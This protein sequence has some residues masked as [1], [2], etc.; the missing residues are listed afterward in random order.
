MK[1]FFTRARIRWAGRILTVALV[2]YCSYN[3]EDIKE[4]FPDLITLQL[5]SYQWLQQIEARRRGGPPP[6]PDKVI[7]VEIDNHTFFDCLKQVGLEDVTD[8][9][10]LAQLINRAVAA[11]AAVVAL[12][13][14]LVSDNL[15]LDDAGR[16]SQN[17]ALFDAIANAAANNV[18]VVLTL[19]FDNKT[20]KRL[21]N[22]ADPA[23]DADAPASAAG[24]HHWDAACKPNQPLPAAEVSGAAAPR[25]SPVQIAGCAETWPPSPDPA[26]VARSGFDAAPLDRRRIPLLLEPLDYVSAPTGSSSEAVLC[27]SF[28]LQIAHA[29]EQKTNAAEPR[30]E[31]RL[32]PEMEEHEFVY[33]SFFPEYSHFD[34]GLSPSWLEEKLHAFNE[35]KGWVPSP[36][37]ESAP[38]EEDVYRFPHV[39]A[40]E[41][42]EGSPEAL[43]QLQGKVV[44]IGGHRKV[45]A[46]SEEWLDYHRGPEGPTL[47]VY[48]HANYVEGLISGNI[49]RPVAR[50]TAVAVDVGIAILIM[51]IC[52]QWAFSFW[53]KTL[54]LVLAVGFAFL[55][56]LTGTARGFCLDFLAVLLI[57][58]LHTAFE[59]YFHLQ[60]HASGSSAE[61][62]HV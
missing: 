32:K 28:A 57:M 27:P 22:I 33:T 47:G 52:A 62:A 25:R 43:R 2:A 11:Q 26:G 31:A 20:M 16:K 13:I 10:F 54:V 19:A 30:V 35:W 42:Y 24:P 40:S 39:L 23:A 56:Y 6:R 46:D 1:P 17:R 14:D 44:L 15:D 21:P 4:H 5:Q 53:K 12:D 48:L 59:H 38:Q 9:V 41:V 34:A 36:A 60:E 7:V 18:P 61:N 50:R 3:F 58:F 8:R 37:A 55:I 49:M 29:Y 45:R 51:W